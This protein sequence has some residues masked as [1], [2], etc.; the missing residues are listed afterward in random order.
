MIMCGLPTSE[1]LFYGAGYLRYGQIVTL[2]RLN[3][4][5]PYPAFYADPDACHPT[6]KNDTRFRVIVSL[7]K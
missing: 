1:V 4:F 5:K 7:A 6:V 3:K 2:A